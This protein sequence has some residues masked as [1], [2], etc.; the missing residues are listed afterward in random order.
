MVSPH[1]VPDTAP[2]PSPPS[3]EDDPDFDDSLPPD[4]PTDGVS[5]ADSL[6]S[7]ASLDVF[8]MLFSA[9]AI[10]TDDACQ[11]H[12]RRGVRI[13]SKAQAS[14]RKRTKR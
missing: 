11:P 4:S 14:F 2:P 3:A 10:E 5:V 8:S 6:D 12:S 1:M 13:R 7:L 9:S